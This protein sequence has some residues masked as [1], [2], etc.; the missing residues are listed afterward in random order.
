[1]KKWIYIAFVII[2]ITVLTGVNYLGVFSP[3]FSAIVNKPIQRVDLIDL[4]GSAHS[5]DELE[6]NETVIYFFASWCNPCFHTL[7]TLDQITTEQE[8]K[9]RLLTIALDEDTEAITKMLNQTGFSGEVWIATEGAMALQKRYFGN[10]KRAI[11][12]V[13]K[14][15]KSTKV[16]ES[17]YKLNSRAEWELV[18]VEGIPILQ[19]SGQ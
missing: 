8:L 12:Y 4:A 13:V 14:I 5:F 18:L 11:P 10:E 15:D 7:A 1:M 2:V 16:M 6:G 9:V 17:S 19:V 3:S